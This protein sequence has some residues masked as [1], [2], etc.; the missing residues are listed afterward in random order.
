[1]TILYIIEKNEL[2]LEKNDWDAILSKR[3]MGNKRF[4][5]LLLEHY[6]LSSSSSSVLEVEDELTK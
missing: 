6:S 2:K 4:D 5:Q 3:I 1:M